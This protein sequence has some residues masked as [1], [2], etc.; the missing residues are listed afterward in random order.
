M[1]AL[2]DMLEIL[3]PAPTT[4]YAPAT[5]D[6]VLCAVDVE[7]WERGH[8]TNQ[9]YILEIGLASYSVATS[10]FTCTPSPP[11]HPRP[12]P[13]RPLAISQSPWNPN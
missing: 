9:E 13:P 4:Q 8:F 5:D 3:S 11:P 2:S 12:A 10:Q 6:I 1:D 7:A